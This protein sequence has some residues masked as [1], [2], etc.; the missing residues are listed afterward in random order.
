[1]KIGIHTM[2]TSSDPIVFTFV[3]PHTSDREIPRA[4]DPSDAVTN[5][6]H[7]ITLTVDDF[8]AAVAFYRDALGLPEV[9]DRSSD[10]GRVLLLDAGRATL[11]LFDETQ[12]AMVDRLEVGRRVSGKVRFA[13]Q[14]PDAVH[15]RR[16][17]CGGSPVRDGCWSDFR[18]AKSHWTTPRCAG[19]GAACGGCRA[20]AARLQWPLPG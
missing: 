19:P 17:R 16:V 6:A 7:T 3:Q 11:E 4:S 14:V 1:M 10:E 5:S 2:A 12:A 15:A 9:A 13:L 20:A 8:D 18:T